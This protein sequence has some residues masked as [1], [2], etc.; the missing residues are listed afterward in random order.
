MTQL[1]RR[2]KNRHTRYTRAPISRISKMPK[3]V[4]PI[5]RPMFNGVFGA[6]VGVSVGLGVGDGVV[7]G[8][9]VI[10]GVGV[11]E[12]VGDG[13]DVTVLEAVRFNTRLSPVS[14]VPVSFAW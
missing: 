9:G 3:M 10:V 11:P 12:G 8:G 6:G 14:Q 13:V 4:S 2:I 7:V 5:I 1:Y